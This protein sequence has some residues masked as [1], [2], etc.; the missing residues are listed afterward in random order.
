MTPYADVNVLLTELV[1][2][3][4]EVLEPNLL[5]VYLYGSTVTEDFDITLSDVDLLVVVAS[6]VDADM[7]K[8]LDNLH[9]T[10]V[11]HHPHWDNRVDIAYLTPQA[12]Q[13]FKTAKSTFAIIS[14]NEPFCYKTAGRE[15]LL[16][17]WMVREQS[18]TLFGSNPQTLIAPISKAEFLD[19]VREH[20][21]FWRE[22][23]LPTIYRRQDQ[24]Y[25]ILTFCRALYA[26]EFEQ[27]VSKQRASSWAQEAFP[28]WQSLIH[29]A[30][31][32]RKIHHDDIDH[33]A[34]LA[35]THK[36][37]NFASSKLLNHDQI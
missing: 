10:L 32:W 15:Y 14:P 23:W 34:T 11:A 21:H 13:T 27:Q 28:Q 6:D 5:G 12:L 2:R 16:N 37:V 7:F 31:L 17:W 4:G 1:K 29:K 8:Q 25:V 24:A 30:F 26:L 22:Q 18:M 36:F 3:L 9:Q 35:E 20:V 33:H 19:S